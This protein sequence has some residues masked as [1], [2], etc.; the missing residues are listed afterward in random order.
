[1]EKFQGPPIGMTDVPAPPYP[2]VAADNVGFYVEPPPPVQT[3]QYTTYQHNPH[4]LPQIVQPVNQVVVVQQLPSEAPGQM[5]C[6]RCQTT[7]LTHIEY[8]NGLL[9]WLICGLLGVFL[10]WPCC[11][12]PFCVDACKDVEHSCPSCNTVLHVYKRR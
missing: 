8:R 4:P 11:L 9:T 1:M 6:P 10:C 7:V 12:I 2:G 3:V 5:M